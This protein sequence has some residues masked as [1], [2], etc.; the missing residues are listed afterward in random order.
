MHLI[1]VLWFLI[2]FQRGLYQEIADGILGAKV[3]LAC[4]SE[5]YL[6]SE[7]CMMELRYAAGTL[8][9]PV[10]FAVVGRGRN[11]L[12][13]EVFIKTSYMYLMYMYLLIYVILILLLSPSSM[14][15]L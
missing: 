14:K 5:E 2:T 12:K 15:Y 7:N 11:W 6:A 4:V 1:S 9:K 10:V 3:V 13:T 8:K